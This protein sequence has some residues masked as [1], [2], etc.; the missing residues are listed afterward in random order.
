M[1]FGFSASGSLNTSEALPVCIQPSFSRRSVSFLGV[2]I[3]SDLFSFTKTQPRR[4][5]HIF[6][7]SAHR[8][9]LPEI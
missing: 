4:L 9:W 2:L 5:C 6:R 1:K 8:T 3:F 7:D